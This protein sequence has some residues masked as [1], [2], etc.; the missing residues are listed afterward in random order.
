M[1]RKALERR[2]EI[3]AQDGREAE[4]AGAKEVGVAEE[5]GATRG[6]G[7]PAKLKLCLTRGGR[8]GFEEHSGC[9]GMLEEEPEEE[10]EEEREMDCFLSSSLLWTKWH[11]IP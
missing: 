9:G 3:S 2:S 8:F 11:R 6:E 10:D 7:N 1:S 4:G 5:W